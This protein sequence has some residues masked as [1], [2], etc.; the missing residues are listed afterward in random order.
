MVLAVARDAAN[1]CSSGASAL[2]VL[3]AD[4]GLSVTELGRRVGLTQSAAAQMVESHEQS[5]LAE[6]SPTLRRWVAVH[7]TSA[8]RLLLRRCWTRAEAR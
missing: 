3:R 7:L 4:P 6:R 5:A 8:A 2:V 1:T